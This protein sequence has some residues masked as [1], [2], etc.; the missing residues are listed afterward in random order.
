MRS[1]RALCERHKDAWVSS[2]FGHVLK[3]LPAA[4]RTCVR[5]TLAPVMHLEL[6]ATAMTAKVA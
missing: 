5:P 2:T 4:Q 1:R 3:F 6:I